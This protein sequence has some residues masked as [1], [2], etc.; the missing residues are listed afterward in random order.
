MVILQQKPGRLY[1]PSGEWIRF[2]D[3]LII[4][5]PLTVKHTGPDWRTPEEVEAAEESRKRVAKEM[6]QERRRNLLPLLP[7]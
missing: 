4:I 7:P 1:P 3:L 2:G 5:E 6:E